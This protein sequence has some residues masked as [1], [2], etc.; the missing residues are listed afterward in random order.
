MKRLLS[1]NEW[2]LK[3]IF[4][5]KKEFLED[6]VFCNRRIVAL[7]I[8]DGHKGFSSGVVR[9]QSGAAYPLEG[10]LICGM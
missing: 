6:I 4:G 10:A 5:G 9:R 3:V 7:Q 8:Y 2:S 1:R